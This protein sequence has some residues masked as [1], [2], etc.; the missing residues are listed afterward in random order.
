M[1]ENTK[2]YYAI[3]PANVRYD[4]DLNPNA[5]LLYGEIT[6]LC[7]EKGYCWASNSY[8]SDLYKVA[9][10]TV[11]R[12]ISQLEKK[13]YIT[14]EIIYKQGTKEIENRFLRINTPIDEKINSSLEE[15]QDPIDKKI[16]DNNTVNNTSNNNTIASKDFKLE[17]E[18][19]IEVW[20]GAK[21]ADKHWISTR[22]TDNLLKV[23][24]TH[25]KKFKTYDEFI[26]STISAMQK[27]FDTCAKRN[28]D[29]THRFTLFDFLNHKSNGYAKYSTIA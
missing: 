3:I 21:Q 15:D 16:K 23:F 27:Y 19:L 17:L 25:R 26:T 18:N 14:R 20:N 12:W 29:F 9:V 24:I 7:N 4:Q 11:S 2:S 6:A 1:E 22:Y 5:K 10:E 13:G 28:D 8:F